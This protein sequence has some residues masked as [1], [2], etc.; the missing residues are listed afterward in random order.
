MLD[1]GLGLC[2][3]FQKVILIRISLGSILLQDI[4]IEKLDWWLGLSM[5]LMVILE[6]HC[7][8]PTM[9]TFYQLIFLPCYVVFVHIRVVVCHV[10]TSRRNKLLFWGS[11]RGYLNLKLLL[12]F[13]L[14]KSALLSKFIILVIVIYKL[15][16]TAI[17]LIYDI[18][19]II[20]GWLNL[21]FWFL[22]LW[23]IHLFHLLFKTFPLIFRLDLFKV[24][25]ITSILLY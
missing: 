7:W 24:L 19:R 23:N 25:A 6:M 8:L 11:T 17:R 15:K 12:D 9:K 18:C 1:S 4:L 22:R 2:V 13:F 16:F 20:V 21:Q 10:P 3:S 14:G 5:R